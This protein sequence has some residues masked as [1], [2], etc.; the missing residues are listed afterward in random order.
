MTKARKEEAAA[1]KEG[2]DKSLK[3]TNRDGHILKCSEGRSRKIWP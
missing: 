1:N 3:W 2:L